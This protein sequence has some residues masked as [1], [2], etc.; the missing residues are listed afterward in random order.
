MTSPA[1]RSRCLLGALVLS[2]CAAGQSRTLA[3]RFVRAGHAGHGPRRAA[4]RHERLALRI[5]DESPAPVGQA[6]A[7]GHVR[8]ERSRAPTAGSRPR[9]CSRRFSRRPRI[10]CSSRTSTSGSGFST[11]PIHRLNRAAQQEPR[12]AEAH[13]ELARI[14]RDWGSPRSGLGAAIARAYF[15]PARQARRT[16][17]GRCSTRSVEPTRHAARSH[18]RSRSTRR[19]HGR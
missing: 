4:A 1:S 16:R 2:G 7:T 8:R 13:E 18:A 3:G 5:H 6:G 9:C 14:W 19:P 17:S 11:R 10:T 12:L 15:D